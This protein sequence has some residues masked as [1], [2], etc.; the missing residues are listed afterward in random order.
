MNRETVIRANCEAAVVVL[1]Q[2]MW[3]R[4]SRGNLAVS[5]FTAWSAAE[6]CWTRRAS[7]FRSASE[8]ASLRRAVTAISL[9]STETAVVRCG[10]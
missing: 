8:S 7:G 9:G 10:I 4:T 6:P 1:F 3:W 2:W 5:Q